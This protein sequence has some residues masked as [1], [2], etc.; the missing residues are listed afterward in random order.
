MFGRTTS[1]LRS[2]FTEKKQANQPNSTLK[3]DLSYFIQF[4]WSQWRFLNEIEEIQSTS[5][6][7]YLNIF[8]VSQK[9]ESHTVNA[10]LI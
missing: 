10:N 4:D 9:Q 3:M 5:N 6:M 8:E 1:P 7:L 2:N